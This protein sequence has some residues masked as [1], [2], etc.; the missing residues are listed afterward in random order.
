M[1]WKIIGL[2]SLIGII[3]CVI[4]LMDMFRSREELPIQWEIEVVKWQNGATVI[5]PGWEPFGFDKATNGI[6][7][8]RVKRGEV[9]ESE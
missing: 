2:A 7:V 5:E 8:K 9:S 4:L 1:F 6:F 3:V